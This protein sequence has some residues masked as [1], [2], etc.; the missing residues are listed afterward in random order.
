MLTAFSF[1]TPNATAWATSISLINSLNTENPSI[2]L[3]QGEDSQLLSPEN[4]PNTEVVTAIAVALVKV[5]QRDRAGGIIKGTSSRPITM[6][7]QTPIV[8]VLTA[9]SFIAPY[10]RVWA[11][12]IPNRESE[13]QT[14]QL[15][16]EAEPNAS[17]QEN[18]LDPRM[19]R[20]IVLALVKVGQRDRAMKLAQTMANDITKASGVP[21]IAIAFSE[22][23]EIDRALQLVQTLVNQGLKPFSLANITVVLAKRGDIGDVERVVQVA[24]SITDEPKRE[25]ALTWIVGALTEAGEIEQALKIT[26][27]PSVDWDKAEALSKIAVALTKAGELE[28]ALQLVQTIIHRRT[29]AIA[30][31]DI[32]MAL[33]EIGE[34]EQALQLPHTI[35]DNQDRD[36]ICLLEL[37]SP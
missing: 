36:V 35:A 33:I 18:F 8:A 12:S 22:V 31:G 16:Q 23:G 24:Q 26:Q 5:G 15:A 29:N 11:T 32:A 30:L 25:R 7:P 2:P 20:E 3:T 28:R 6:K 4:S 27:N 10:T 9:I 19:L 34:I 17:F 13:Y 1:I 21:E 14:F 37:L